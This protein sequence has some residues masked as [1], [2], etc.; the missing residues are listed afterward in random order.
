ME[1]S[2]IV[3]AEHSED[4]VK[5]ITYELVSC[6]LK[7]Q[8]IQP[9]AIKV[10]ILGAQVSKLA[11]EI[12]R[13]SGQ[14]VIAI[15]APDLIEYNGE[16]YRELLAKELV[17]FHPR[18]VCVAHTSQG[19]DFAPALAVPLNADCITGIEAIFKKDGLLYF[20]R[21]IYGGKIVAHVRPNSETSILTIQPG[22]FKPIKIEASASG[23]IEASASGFIEASAS[24]FVDIKSR[25]C[26]PRRS[27]SMGLRKAE[28]D[29]SGISEAHII[30]A[31]GQGIGKKDNLDMIYQLAALFRK[32]AVAGSRIVCDRGWLQYKCQVGVTG[33][34]VAPDLY[35]ACGISGAMQH[36]TGMRASGFIVAIN[37]DPAA[38]VFQVADIGIVEDLTTFIPTFIEQY[39]KFKRVC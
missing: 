11:R 17:E 5:P 10:I 20:A 9:L 14:E 28:A 19:L 8:Q 38:A 2:L 37:T 24:G 31:A 26:R 16:I 34:T 23:F 30:V 15:Q 29:T 25:S 7:L 32:S 18:Y 22:I 27:R 3:I 36:L 39:E 21:P 12:A 1:R 35:I 13:N 33:A 4:R 6:A